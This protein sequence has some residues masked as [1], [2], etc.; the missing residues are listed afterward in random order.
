MI[1]EM[2]A[3]GATIAELLEAA[4]VNPAELDE[5]W[6]ILIQTQKNLKKLL[7]NWKASGIIKS[8]KKER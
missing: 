2:I 4:G 5:D 8:S 3:N 7:T 1:K 6:K